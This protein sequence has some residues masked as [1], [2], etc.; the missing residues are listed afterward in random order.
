MS[1]W[2][3]WHGI[4]EL[5]VNGE[6]LSGDNVGSEDFKTN[7]EKFVGDEDL[8]PCQIFNGDETGL[9]YWMLPK[10]KF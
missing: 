10:K 3:N 1:R 2:K 7:F 8:L 4:R 6:I 5:G 9:F